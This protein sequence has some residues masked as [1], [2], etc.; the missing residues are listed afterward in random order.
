MAHQ[1]MYH[2]TS[3]MRVSGRHNASKEGTRPSLAPIFKGR[4]VSARVAREVLAVCRKRGISVAPLVEGL[5]FDECLL[6]DPSARHSWDD[7]VVLLDRVQAAAGGPWEMERVGFDTIQ[8]NRAFRLLGR[9]ILSPRQLYLYGVERISRTHYS[10]VGSRVEPIDSSRLRCTFVISPDHVDSLAYQYATIGALR[11]Y[12]RLLGHPA[13]IVEAEIMPRKGVFVV[14][15]PPGRRAKRAEH[16]TKNFLSALLAGPSF[17]R[18]PASDDAARSLA[19]SFDYSGLVETVQALG[20]QLAA[21]RN[22]TEIGNLVVEIMRQHFC[23][24]HVVL[25]VAA[26]QD[27]FEIVREQGIECAPSSRCSRVIREGN[28][29]IGRIEAD[30]SIM[31]D[32][33]ASPLFEALLPWIAGALARCSRSLSASVSADVTGGATPEHTAPV[34][35]QLTDRQAQVLALLAQGKTNKEI[36]TALDIA[37]RTVEVHVSEL[38]KRADAANR[39]ELLAHLLATT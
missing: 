4:E 14:T 13:A 17:N 3:D 26:G 33:S 5:G 1:R 8:S 18:P 16:T 30:A 29:V 37:T 32:G 31:E 10:C 36:A 24:T 23:A 38:L 9:L 39:T 21:A 12:P 35:W 19:I 34:G 15:L 20:Q 22:L 6:G 11:A 25:A 7:F 27:G 28:L 2:R